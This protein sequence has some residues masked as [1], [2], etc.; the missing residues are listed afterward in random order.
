LSVIAYLAFFVFICCYFFM[1]YASVSLY[2]FIGTYQSSKKE[3]NDFINN[4]PLVFQ[5]VFGEKT[6][7]YFLLSHLSRPDLYCDNM[8][9]KSI[10]QNRIHRRIIFSC[11]AVW[12]SI[13]L[14]ALIKS[15]IIGSYNI[16]AILWTISLLPVLIFGGRF[17][18][19]LG[20]R[21]HH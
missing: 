5:W 11:I 12:F 20:K 3:I 4:L 21:K 9:Q 7:V 6:K 2:H 8:D 19:K 17:G 16:P 10:T 14:L 18:K 1:L 15:T 13:F